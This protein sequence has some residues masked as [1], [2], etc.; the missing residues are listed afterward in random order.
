MR[1][2][3]FARMGRAVLQS[4]LTSESLGDF[5]AIDNE[6]LFDPLICRT[7]PAIGS[8]CP[9]NRWNIVARGVYRSGG[10][11]RPDHTSRN[12]RPRVPTEARASHLYSRPFNANSADLHHVLA[13][14]VGRQRPDECRGPEKCSDDGTTSTCL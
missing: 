1:P 11:C 5:T 3:T 6:P 13:L 9:W 10:D 7:P 12:Q 8:I 4:S 14:R 2:T